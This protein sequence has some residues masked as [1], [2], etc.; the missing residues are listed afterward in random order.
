[1][2]LFSLPEEQQVVGTGESIEGAGA[3][4]LNYSSLLNKCQNACDLFS[5]RNKYL[6]LTT[7]SLKNFEQLGNSINQIHHL[8]GRG[9]GNI[10]KYGSN[11]INSPSNLIK[12]PKQLHGIITQFFN[13]GGY[14]YMNGA[15]GSLQGYI[16]GLSFSQQLEWGSAVLN[17]L[18]ANGTMVGFDPA[19]FGLFIP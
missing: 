6:E 14:S 2:G 4:G 16:S 9:W 8:V 15:G 17:Y 18:L 13:S 11:I 5:F 1:M 3:G 12:L 19:N 10:T 7:N